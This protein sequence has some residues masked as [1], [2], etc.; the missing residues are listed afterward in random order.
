MCILITGSAGFI[1]Y[2]LADQLLQDNHTV[3]GIDYLPAC[4]DLLLVKARLQRLQ[5]YA[6]FCF[7][8]VDI[9]DADKLALLFSQHPIAQVIH[10]AGK[11]GIRGS[12]LYPNSYAEINILGWIN[13]LENCRRFAIPKVILASSSSVYS[14]SQ[15][16]PFREDERSGTPA[17]IYG[18][19][20][21]TQEALAYNYSFLYGMDITV[22]RLFTVYGAFYRS[23]MALS[24]FARNLWRGDRVM[25]S[26]NGQVQ[27]D[28]T[29]VSDVVEVFV[30]SLTRGGT[31]YEVYNVGYGQPVPLTRVIQFMAEYWQKEVIVEFQPLAPEE[32]VINHADT[33]KLK[34]DFHYA[35]QV[36]I[37]AGIP[38][39]LDWY[40]SF[41]G[42]GL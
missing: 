29:H 35:P 36:S 9:G 24:I 1:G 20:K 23:D 16:L 21:Q 26:G 39:F 14:N 32:L 27:R 42:H 15:K 7:H 37:E 41:Y 30:R 40:E 18:T 11:T 22:L 3:L 12:R 31:G 19:T 5:K 28:F 33:G 17:S 34:A 6:N 13:V 38:A 8:E 4:R 2:H 25:I 10:L